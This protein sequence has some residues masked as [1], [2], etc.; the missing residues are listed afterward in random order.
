MA[1]TYVKP[2]SIHNPAT[3]TA[4]P[5]TWGDGV[6]ASLDLLAPNACVVRRAAVQSVNDS[7]ATLI[8]FDTEDIDDNGFYA[9]GSPTKIT[10][11]RK[12]IYLF[13]VRVQFASDA[14]GYRVVTMPRGGGAADIT[15]NVPP[16]NGAESV[17]SFPFMTGERSAGDYYEFNVWHNAGGALNITARVAVSL[18]QDRT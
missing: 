9:A 12:G 18:I 10:L 13:D 14:D 7:S 16:T 1:Y 3:G 8:T 2:S 6:N 15:V 5:A 4:A 11:P 17:V